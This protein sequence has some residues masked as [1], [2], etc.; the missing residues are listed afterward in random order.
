MSKIF[1]NNHSTVNTIIL[2]D[3]RSSN[4]IKGVSFGILAPGVSAVKTLYLVNTGV[5]GDRVIDL[6]IQSRSTDTVI[7]STSAERDLQ[8]ITETLRTLVVATVDPIKV[9]Q[10][11]A[12]K[13]G[14]VEWPGLANLNTFN[15]DVWD[16][17]RT[18]EALVNTRIECAGPSALRMESI[19]LERQ[20]HER[21]I[22]FEC[23]ADHTREPPSNYYP[24]DELAHITRL[25]IASS[26][27]VD[28]EPITDTGVYRI[29]W[30]RI[31]KN[32]DY[33]SLSTTLIPLPGLQPPPEGLIAL[34]S[35][36]PTGALHVPIPLTL[37]VRNHHPTRSANV[38]VQ[39]EPD[40]SDAF[41]VAGLR[42]GRIPI[43]MP[44][45]E[46]TLTWRLIPIECGHVKLPRLK[47]IDKRPIFTGGAEPTSESITKGEPV[48][49]V[50]VRLD[51]RYAPSNGVLS[52]ELSMKDNILGTVL[53]LP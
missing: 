23:S 32:G 29:E 42:S 28:D 11:V 48:K 7:D 4:F 21:A 22:M 18:S 51:Q 9:T 53:I 36:P 46:E 6:S 44:G 3:E 19:K 13:G 1:V 39:L 26:D 35:V 43:L 30:R 24:G 5:P 10:S 8:D 38:I 15:G 25:A 47:V 41:V 45:D 12:Y 49:V 17:S 33:G 31:W 50:D 16:H 2:G 14:L 27:D 37:T 52:S 20:V 40:A 34:L